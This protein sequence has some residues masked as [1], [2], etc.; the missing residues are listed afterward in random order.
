[1]NFDIDDLRDKI[2]NGYISRTK[3]PT[4][5]NLFI[6]N[7][8]HKTLR[9]WEWNKTLIHCR[10][11]IVDKDYNIL[12]KPFPKFFD[13]NQYRDLRNCVYNLYGVMYKD[14][15]SDSYTITEKLD[16]S[17]GILYHNGNDWSI[18][19][20]GSFDGPQA[21]KA[22]EILH[23][24]YPIIQPNPNFTYLFEII[25]PENTLVVDYGNK[26]DLILIDVI[27]TESGKPINW[28][29]DSSLC[30]LYNIFPQVT[31]YNNTIE[32]LEEFLLEGNNA[33]GFVVRYDNGLYVKVKTESYK[34]L[35]KLLSNISDRNIL[36]A[37]EDGSII[38]WLSTLI[39]NGCKNNSLKYMLERVEFFQNEYKN[40]EKIIKD[41]CIWDCFLNDRDFGIKYGNHELR[42]PIF[43]YRKHKDWKST[44]Y[45]YLR[46]KYI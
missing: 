21:I 28:R 18:A 25:Y 5:D 42:G 17:L 35:A 8:T 37:I 36:N 23:N 9:E 40:V 3:H 29:G 33:E 46:H 7:Y 14:C 19:T 12:W 16:G 44:I 26:E 13:F 22:N 2:S 6:L 32:E 20:R 27:D 1:M 31:Y 24:K 43:A 39:T 41:I 10:G 15:F 38:S 45:S 11:T 4:N 34:L 30:N